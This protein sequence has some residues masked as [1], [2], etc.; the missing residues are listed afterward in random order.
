MK[1]MARVIILLLAV[2]ALG[3]TSIVHAQSNGLGI[4]PRKDYT[5]K[6]GGRIS[7][8]LFISNLSQ[9]DDLRVAI[10]LSLIHI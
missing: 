5:V 8:K 3:S 1:R 7:D 10:R 6:A 4:T 9:K 2:A